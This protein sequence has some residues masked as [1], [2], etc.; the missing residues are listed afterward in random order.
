M[1]NNLLLSILILF[2]LD[3]IEVKA[4]D[5]PKFVKGHNICSVNV[6]KLRRKMGLKVTGSPAASSWLTLPKTSKPHVG[7]VRYNSHHVSV[8][9][10]GGMC[11]NPS[12]KHQK[13]DIKKC[14][15]IWKGKHYEWRG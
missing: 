2:F 8:Y 4:Y 15:Y 1:L 9:L 12:S 6:N 14:E 7:S 3:S 13:W 5:L 11:A 10:G